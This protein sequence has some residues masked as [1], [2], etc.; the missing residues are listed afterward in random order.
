MKKL[1]LFVIVLICAS[2]ALAYDR[3][4]ANDG[5]F[6]GTNNPNQY[7]AQSIYNQYGQ[8]GSQYSSQSINNPY[9]Q[10]GSQYSTTSPNNPYA[11]NGYAI[12]V[13]SGQQKRYGSNPYS[14]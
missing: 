13:D 8:Y 9:G 6:L 10:Y 7:D 1:A 12:N 2:P 11:Q 5:T 4:Y 3:I 14:Y